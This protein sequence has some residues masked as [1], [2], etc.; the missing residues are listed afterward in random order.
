MKVIAALLVIL[1]IAAGCSKE[2]KTS[3]QQEP[4]QQE[5]KKEE[6]KPEPEKPEYKHTFPLTGIG[7]D[8]EIGTRPVA[9]MVN[10]HP[11][12]R[13]QSGLHKADVVYEVLAEGDITRLL[14]V[15]QSEQPDSIGPVRSARDYY[16]ELSKGFDAFYVTHGYSPEAKQMLDSGYVPSINGLFY[17]GTLFK[18]ADFRKAPHNS[19]ITYENVLKG[20]EQKGV[21]MEKEP[22]AYTFLSEQELDSLTED[23]SSTAAD[24]TVE[25]ADRSYATAQYKYNETEK[26]Y[27]RFSM[28]EQTIDRETET[29]VTIDNLFI[30][31]TGHRVIDS[32][33]RR[34]ID[35]KSG[36]SAYLI[37]Q[38]KL[39]KV[40]WKN[41]TGRIIPVENGQP[42][43]L[44]PGKTW[45]SIIPESPGLEQQVTIK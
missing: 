35:L 33:G 44:V 28:D 6:K 26:K 10:N 1:L 29:P 31:E 8:E 19:Y 9:V 18:R 12:A 41:E 17:D 36:G 3:Q 22:A 37:Q 7:T 45:I 4:E 43:G 13:P 42:A 23:E 40:E 2:E 34:Q 14:A 11:K 15:F 5:E 21:D 38:G 20:A 16:I 24:V 32:A 39:R 27:E 30:V 25:H